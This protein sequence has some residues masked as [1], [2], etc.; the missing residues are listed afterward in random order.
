MDALVISAATVDVTAVSIGGDVVLPFSQSRLERLQT[1]VG[2]RLA[3]GVLDGYWTL[4][5]LDGC[6]SPCNRSYCSRCEDNA[7]R[8]ANRLPPLVH[9]NSAREWIAAHP[10]QWEALLRSRLADEIATPDLPTASQEASG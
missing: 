3:M 2:K 1:G 7:W 5:Q 8:V 10:E 4:E 6:T 9:S